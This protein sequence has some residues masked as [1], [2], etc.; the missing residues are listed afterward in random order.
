MKGSNVM[1]LESW[2]W[3]VLLVVFFIIEIMTAGSLV[4]IWACVGSLCAYISALL[5]LGVTG[6]IIVFLVSTALSFALLYKFAK[7][8]LAR[9]TLKSNVDKYVGQTAL[10]INDIDNILGTGEVIAN[11][12]YWSAKS[13]DDNLKISK[14]TSVIIERVEGSKL[15]VKLNNI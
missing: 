1:V 13:V 6:Q 5:G 7:E 12:I 11:G 3:L 9:P 10:C 14:D 15:I 8:K 2:I 4:S